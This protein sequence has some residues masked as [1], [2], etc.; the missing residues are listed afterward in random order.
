MHT[1]EQIG[2]I[3]KAHLESVER[4]EAERKARTSQGLCQDVCDEAPKDIQPATSSLLDGGGTENKKKK[5]KVAG[6]KTPMPLL[7]H[8][9]SVDELKTCGYKGKGLELNNVWILWGCGS[10]SVQIAGVRLTY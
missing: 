2:T 8:A 5:L 6:A 9:T 10:Q 1:L 3:A 7:Q 4:K